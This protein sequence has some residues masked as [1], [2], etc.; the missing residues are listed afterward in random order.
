MQ[1]KKREIIIV[2]NDLVITNILLVQGKNESDVLQVL[3]EVEVLLRGPTAGGFFAEWRQQFEQ[4]AA[5]G[6][7]DPGLKVGDL[8]DKLNLSI[9]TLGRLCYRAYGVSPMKYVYNLR[10]ERAAFL[11][12]RDYGR[13]KDVAFETGFSSLSYF[14]RCYK[15]RYGVPPGVVRKGQT[16]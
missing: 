7:P 13:V 11:L 2:G 1:S 5:E 8:A 16:M 3:K 4:A 6:S 14:S 10:L 15:D 9:S 12:S